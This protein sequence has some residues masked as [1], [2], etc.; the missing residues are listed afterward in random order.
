MGHSHRPAATLR[1]S[2]MTKNGLPFLAVFGLSLI[3]WAAMMTNTTR[4]ETC[5]EL[6]SCMVTCSE[7]VLYGGSMDDVDT[8]NNEC[9]WSADQC[10]PGVEPQLSEVEGARICAG[11]HQCLV[12][13]AEGV[14]YGATDDELFTCQDECV[15]IGQECSPS[16]E[17]YTQNSSP[18]EPYTQDS[19]SNGASAGGSTCW[20]SDSYQYTSMAPGNHTSAATGVAEA[21]QAVQFGFPGPYMWALVIDTGQCPD[22]L[23]ENMVVMQPAFDTSGPVS[24]AYLAYKKAIVEAATL[25]DILVHL[26]SATVQEMNENAAADEQQMFEFIQIIEE[27]TTGFTILSE[28]ITGDTAVVTAKACQWDSASNIAAT[29][30]L[31]DGVWKLVHEQSNN[32]GL[33]AAMPEDPQVFV[34]ADCS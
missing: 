7:Q 6:H 19:S 29:F 5:P 2:F 23:L 4:A 10:E 25:Q 8:C 11:M 32:D 3:A 24:Q 9:L 34:P 15:E 31:E 1:A 12:S 14:L 17:T 18:S 20:Y 13:C 26:A 28:E 16:S 21:G 30:A 27:G 22:Q 33:M